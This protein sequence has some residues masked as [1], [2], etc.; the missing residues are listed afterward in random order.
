MGSSAA[1]HDRG[2][3]DAN[4]RV[5]RIDSDVTMIRTYGAHERVSVRRANAEGDKGERA[6]SSFSARLSRLPCPFQSLQS[7]RSARLPPA[8]LQPRSYEG[9]WKKQSGPLLVSSFNL[10]QANEEER[11]R[12]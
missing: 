8:I 7:R 4:V 9:A 5:K 11:S 2:R 3:E 6:A 10:V 12:L 1:L